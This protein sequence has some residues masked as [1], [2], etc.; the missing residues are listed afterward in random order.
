MNQVHLGLH[1]NNNILIDLCIYV[2]RIHKA[3]PLA[4]GKCNNFTLTYDSPSTI[5]CLKAKF[6]VLCLVF[7]I[8]FM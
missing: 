8:A 3:K 7:M 5:Q 2:A 4:T 6:Y 1:R